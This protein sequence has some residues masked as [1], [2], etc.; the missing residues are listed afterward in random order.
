MS[1]QPLQFSVYKGMKGNHG[2]L[3]FNL[4]LPHYYKGKEKSYDGEGVFE[5]VDGRWKLKEGWNK[6]EGCVFLEITSAT[7]QNVYDWENKIIMALSVTDIGKLL[8]TLRTGDECKIMHDPGANT[9]ASGVVKKWLDV[10]SPKG[11]KTGVFFSVT[12]Q[13]AGTDNVTHRVPLSGDEAMVLA[14]LLSTAISRALN[15]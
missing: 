13:A 5:E 3:Q 11:V 10:S 8:L 2:A 9:T 7:G 1:M 14:Q 12:K 15:W 6:R 4:Q